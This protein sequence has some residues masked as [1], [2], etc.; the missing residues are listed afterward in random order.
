M[1]ILIYGS[2][3]IGNHYANGFVER[4]HKVYVTDIDSKAL[5]RMKN[6]IYPQRYG[7]WN[8]KIQLFPLEHQLIF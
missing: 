4:N 6:T 1:K 7:S 5:E 2:G 3:S 8:N